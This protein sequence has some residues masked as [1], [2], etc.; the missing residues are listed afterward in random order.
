MAISFVA[1]G[2]VGVTP[3]NATAS[4]TAT[5]MTLP[6]G[7]A[8]GD[9]LLMHCGF[10]TGAT[11]SGQS[12]T[13]PSGWANL[14][15][16]AGSLASSALLSTFYKVAGASEGTPGSPT[17]VGGTTGTTGATG[18]CRVTAWR[19]VDTSSMPSSA[20]A[21]TS[22]GNVFTA[23]Q[24]IGVITGFTPTANDAY[25]VVYGMK[26]D[27]WTSVA[28]LSGD[29]LTWAQP[30]SSTSTNAGDASL[31]VATAPITGAP[32]AISNKTFTVTGGATE[33]SAARM[34]ALKPTVPPLVETLTDDFSAG[35]IDSAKWTADSG[36]TQSGGTLNI[37]TSTAFPS[38][39]SVNTYT[40]TDSALFAE[41]QAT[42]T[43]AT[44]STV[45]AFRDAANANAYRIE[46]YGD[47]NLYL[48]E[49]VATVYDG[50]SVA[51][52]ATAHR[53][54]RIRHNTSAGL[55]YWETS[56]DGLNWTVR[57]SKVPASVLTGQQVRLMAGFT[58]AESA[59]TAV[60]DNLNITPSAPPTRVPKR[61]YVCGNAMVRA[62]RW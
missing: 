47:G 14:G 29:G 2:V 16:D 18:L 30:V 40:L 37:L 49:V 36:V 19:G 21:G 31:V 20:L 43:G 44:T 53:W 28:A 13:A 1:A 22:P 24:N 35:T 50:T 4:M 38:L 57:R 3:N 8:A 5:G 27:D 32:V 45:L 39:I 6:A 25:V 17:F 60:F 42:G 11:T 62:S 58:G 55:V 51:Y 59:S 15:V 23:Q 54:W 46:R 9:L 61:R 7:V 33:N 52:D 34:F 48:V 41:V 10:D 12:I 26:K 56:P